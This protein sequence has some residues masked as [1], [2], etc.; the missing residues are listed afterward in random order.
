MANDVLNR[1][2]CQQPPMHASSSGLSG[3]VHDSW[4]Q[5]FGTSAAGQTPIQRV[6]AKVECSNKRAEQ[7]NW[8]GLQK[9][10]ILS[11]FQIKRYS[12]RDEEE[13]YVF[14]EHYRH[15]ELFV[16]LQK[17]GFETK[18]WALNA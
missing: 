7:K 9:T 15:V 8:L 14:Y 1:T 4:I 10:L 6:A 16:L 11:G 3:E 12:W 17:M 2:G 18:R 13:Y 5:S